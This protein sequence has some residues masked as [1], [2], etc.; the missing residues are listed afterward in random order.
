MK[1]KNVLSASSMSGK[2]EY[3]LATGDSYT[4]LATRFQMGRPA[5]HEAFKLL[6]TKSGKYFR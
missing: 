4:R 3:L 2:W 1:I 6:V 5:I